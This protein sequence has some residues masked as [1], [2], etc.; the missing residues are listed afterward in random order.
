M[1]KE[2]ANV[3]VKKHGSGIE[4]PFTSES[5]TLMRYLFLR[6]QVLEE[7]SQRVQN[8]TLSDMEK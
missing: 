7:T 8:L 6:I 4:G 3:V 1:L 2:N 5:H